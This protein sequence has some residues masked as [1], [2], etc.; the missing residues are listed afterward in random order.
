[1]PLSVLSYFCGREV[2]VLSYRKDSF[3]RDKRI[4][5]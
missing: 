2:R 5:F 4:S 1:M 3:M